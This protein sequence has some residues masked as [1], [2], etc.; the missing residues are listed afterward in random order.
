M[1]F[2][3][4]VATQSRKGPRSTETK[5]VRQGLR[6]RQSK[7]K[8][9]RPHLQNFG[10]LDILRNPFHGLLQAL[11]LLRR[12]QTNSSITVSVAFMPWPGHSDLSLLLIL[13]LSMTSL[14]LCDNPQHENVICQWFLG[15]LSHYSVFFGRLG[16][17]RNFVHAPVVCHLVCNCSEYVLARSVPYR[18][19]PIW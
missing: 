3:A 11:L 13:V 4:T 15:P 8:S 16:N 7:S 19:V 10:E 14:L 2:S 17:T 5:V 6:A 1:C 18:T 9:R 12:L